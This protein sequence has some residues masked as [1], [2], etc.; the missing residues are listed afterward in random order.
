MSDDFYDRMMTAM[1]DGS[2]YVE[3][4]VEPHHTS[5]SAHAASVMADMRA[6]RIRKGERVA[7]LYSHEHDAKLAASGH[8]E[9]V[10]ATG[11]TMDQAKALLAAGAKWVGPEL[12][13]PPA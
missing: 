9:W 13:K 3:V 12:Q 11:V 2:G 7:Y 8:R 5:A 1:R 10:L 6:E 4:D